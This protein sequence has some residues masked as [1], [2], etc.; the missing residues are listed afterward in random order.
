MAEHGICVRRVGDVEIWSASPDGICPREAEKL[1]TELR[2]ISAMQKAQGIGAAIP[3]SE[4]QSMNRLEKLENPEKPKKVAAQADALAKAGNPVAGMVKI[5]Q[6]GG[7][8]AAPS[9]TGEEPH[10]RGLRDASELD[11][12]RDAEIELVKAIRENRRERIP[13]L[14]AK[15]RELRHEEAARLVGA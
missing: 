15:L 6:S 7:V 14:Q 10:N 13:A 1:T 8:A 3:L 11:S 4:G 12:S 2:E 9:T 5:H